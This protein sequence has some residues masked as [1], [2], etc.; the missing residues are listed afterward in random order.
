MAEDS[1]DFKQEGEVENTTKSDDKPL[2]ATATSTAASIPTFSVNIWPPSQR[3]REAVINRLIENLSHTSTLSKRYGTL[4][5]DEASAIARRIEQEAFDLAST[6]VSPPSAAKADE[7]AS[8]EASV[9]EGIEILQIYSKEIS[10][11]MIE[12][13][14]AKGSNV[15]PIPAE[16]NAASAEEDSGDV[17]DSVPTP[18]EPIGEEIASGVPEPSVG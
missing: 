3:T 12:S 18:A 6:Y 4:P 9:D 1:E 11:R 10:R 16:E 2:P 8:A 13:V 17:A 5:P 15:S 14:K 7:V